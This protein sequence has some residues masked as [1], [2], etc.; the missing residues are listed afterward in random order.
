MYGWIL[1]LECFVVDS[2]P[3]FAVD[4]ASLV[5][6]SLPPFTL[7]PHSCP[8]T[9]LVCNYGNIPF[10]FLLLFL[11]WCLHC[12]RFSFCYC[13]CCYIVF[14]FVVIFFAIQFSSLRCLL[15]RLHFLLSRKSKTSIPFIWICWNHNNSSRFF[16]LLFVCNVMASIVFRNGIFLFEPILYV[17]ITH[18]EITTDLY[19]FGF[20]EFTFKIII[21]VQQKK[22]TRQHNETRMQ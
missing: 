22:A 18:R 7:A 21:R 10:H 2:M 3:L 1:R 9:T 15:F 4:A 8:L 6:A 19:L 17:H 13:Y 12:Y 20:F 11:H 16:W 14:T 5:R